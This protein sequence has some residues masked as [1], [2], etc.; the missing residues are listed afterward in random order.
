MKLPTQA[1]IVNAA[2]AVGR[3]RVWGL[4]GLLAAVLQATVSQ[5]QSAPD[6]DASALPLVTGVVWQ[7]HQNNT[8]PQG[9]W[10]RLG[11]TAL[12]VQWTVVDG[13]AY[14][15]PPPQ[16]GNHPG[17][18]PAPLLP[19]WID[20]GG[21]AWAQHVTLG[22]VGQFDEATAR[23]HLDAMVQASANW[24]R[25][26]GAAPPLPVTDWY[27]PV[28]FDPSWP[29]PA[30]L[31]MLLTLLPRPLWISV[32]DNTNQGPDALV[33]YLE[34]WLPDDV[35]VY[36]QDGVGVHTRDASTARQHADA[37]VQRLGA[38]RVRLIAEAFRPAT[39]PVSAPAPTDATGLTTA[40]AAVAS[41][42][43]AT[44]DELKQQLGAYKGLVTYLFEGPT[45]V[46]DATVEQ[47]LQP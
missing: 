45:Y 13:W 20:I 5:A 47:L 19:D 37:L 42:R 23:T 31:K 12:L 38:S 18:E 34:G 17:P 24:G 39:A 36:F 15:Q 27:F 35:G 28:E 32:Y 1:A 26:V 9:N 30:N 40:T 29:P 43:P 46:P 10:Q 33:H 21:Q 25:V 6:A 22:L 16:P 8:Q 14:I 44:A 11:A 7:P 3:A 41:F 4:A 2:L